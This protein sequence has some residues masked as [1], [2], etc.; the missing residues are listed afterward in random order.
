MWHH[1]GMHFIT[2]STEGNRYFCGVI[3][4]NSHATHLMATPPA[5]PLLKLTLS[6]SKYFKYMLGMSTVSTA[7][8]GSYGVSYQVEWTGRQMVT[9]TRHGVVI[10]FR[11]PPS[12]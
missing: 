6:T 5:T 1:I 3:E 9:H 10:P 4:I 7:L 12:S 11:S 2:R 8:G